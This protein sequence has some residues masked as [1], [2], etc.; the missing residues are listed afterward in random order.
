MIQQLLKK[1]MLLLVGIWLL[2]TAI[3]INKA[4]H[5]DDTFHLEAAQHILK[6]PLKP[7]SGMIR[8]DKPEATPIH[9]GNQPP[10]LFYMIAGMSLIFGFNEIGLHLLTALFCFL[11]LYWFYKAATLLYGSDKPV[12]LLALLGFCPAFVVNQNLM[13]DVP[14]LAL[15]LG[16]FYYISLAGRSH[17]TRHYVI[18]MC[19]LAAG[20]FTKYTFLPVLASIFAL[21]ILRKQYRNLRFLLIPAG[22]LIL[23]SLWNYWEFGGIHILERR[24]VPTFSRWDLLWS[25]FTSLGCIAPFGFLLFDYLIKGRLSSY[26]VYIILFL[27]I[28]IVFFSF[29]GTGSDEEQLN[30]L[31]EIA[32]FTNGL[33]IIAAILR[34]GYRSFKQRK[35]TG[36]IASDEGVLF[37]LILT[38]SVFIILLAPFMAPRHVLLIVPLILLLSAPKISRCKTGLRVTAVATSLVLSILLGIS[39]WLFADYYRTTSAAIM[40]GMPPNSKVWATGAGGWQWYS[41]KDGM[42]EYSLENP[43]ARPGDYIVIATNTSNHR[44]NA[45]LPVRL[46]AKIWGDEVTPLTYFSVNKGFS[47][48]YTSFGRPSWRLSKKPA[49]TIFVL[50]CIDPSKK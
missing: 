30:W 46:L 5:V 4:F 17:Q 34:I 3:N 32:F 48:Y 29:Y 50:Q 2:L 41:K 45:D 9:T 36:F 11:A 49:D 38:I 13:T 15:L 12:F 27:F 35:F 18:A 43:Q 42:T 21:F 40:R 14:L 8:W 22:L 44:I 25:F 10:L 26:L 31:L 24:T 28:Q 47:M 19:L 33:I 37:M 16:V 7:M 20:C 6:D 23:W 39:D 1:P